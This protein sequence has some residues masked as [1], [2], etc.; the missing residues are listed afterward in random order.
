MGGRAGAGRAAAAGSRGQT[1][2]QL[3]RSAGVRQRT[4]AAQWPGKE[5]ARQLGGE[6]ARQRWQR[7]KY[8]PRRYL[9][10]TEFVT[11]AGLQLFIRAPHASMPDLITRLTA[12]WDPSSSP[13]TLT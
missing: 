1:G 8:Q 13:L 11:L 3:D 7:V 4:A 12:S 10:D 2:R 9:T 5:A 6:A